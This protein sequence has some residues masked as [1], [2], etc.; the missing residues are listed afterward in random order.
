MCVNSRNVLYRNQ[1]VHRITPF[2]ISNA[3][4]AQ[5]IGSDVFQIIH[6]SVETVW[7]IIFFSLFFHFYFVFVGQKTRKKYYNFIKIN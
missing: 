6:I 5:H 3:D 2:L 7:T 1:N 4:F